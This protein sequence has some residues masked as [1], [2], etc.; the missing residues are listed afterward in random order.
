M[1]RTSA[2]SAWGCIHNW[3]WEPMGQPIL[4]GIKMSDKLRTLGDMASLGA[5]H[6]HM[7]ATL[8][9]VI[10]AALVG[11]GQSA[12]ARITQ[13]QITSQ[14]PAFGGMSFGTGGPYE[15]LIGRASGEVDPNDPLN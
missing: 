2:T 13:L 5:R 6:E 1:W 10:V 15:T 14:T 4:G 8:Y 9:G 3:P 11:I 7:R 12:D